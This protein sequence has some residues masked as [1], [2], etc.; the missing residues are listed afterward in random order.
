MPIIRFEFQTDSLNDEPSQFVLEIEGTIY[1]TVDSPEHKGFDE[2]EEVKVGKILLNLVQRDR[3]WDAKESLFQVMDS[4]SSET[5]ECYESIFDLKT[6]DWK[7]SIESIYEPDFFTHPNLLLIRTLDLDKKWQGKGIGSAVVKQVIAIFGST[8]GL[9]CCK[10]FPLQ[11]S[12]WKGSRGEEVQESAAEKKQRKQ[13]F[14]KVRK[15]WTSQ[16][17]REIRKSEFVVFSP[18]FDGIPSHTPLLEKQE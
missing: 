13:A 10:P 2:W 18:E 11:Y 15:F 17:F 1:E 14:R 12:G 9:I 6:N 5:C 8:C 4:I 7:R 16:G 3:I